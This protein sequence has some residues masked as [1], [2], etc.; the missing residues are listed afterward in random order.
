M[1]VGSVQVTE[2]DAFLVEK[3]HASMGFFFFFLVI[4]TKPR[5]KLTITYNVSFCMMYS[6]CYLYFPLLSVP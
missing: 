2:K 6:L 1:A 5:V 4:V 3:V